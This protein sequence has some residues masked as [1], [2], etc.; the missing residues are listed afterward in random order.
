MVGKRASL[1]MAKNEKTP[2]SQGKTGAYNMAITTGLEYA[3]ILFVAL[4][5]R[6]ACFRF[7]RTSTHF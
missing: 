1:G 6:D 4:L 5:L 2:V 3:C 7:T